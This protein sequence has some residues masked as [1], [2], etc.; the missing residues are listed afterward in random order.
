MDTSKRRRFVVVG[1]SVL[2][3]VFAVGIVILM[4]MSNHYFASAALTS[5]QATATAQQTAMTSSPPGANQT[6]PNWLTRPSFAGKVLHWTQIVYSYTAGGPDPANGQPLTGDIWVQVDTAGVPTTIHA[7]YTFTNGTFYQ[8]F[9]QTRTTATSIL[10]KSYFTNAGC[11]VVQKVFS[12]NDLLS[13]LP[14]FA[15]VVALPSSGYSIKGTRVPLPIPTTK[16]LAGVSPLTTYV[17]STT[18]QLWGLNR[19]LGNGMH[20]TQTMEVGLDSRVLATD[21]KLLDGKG[22][23]IQENWQTYGQLE[24]YDT[25]TVPNTVFSLSQHLGGGCHA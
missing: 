12:N 8:E 10:G 18:T 19:S 14:L 6:P 4:Q 2:L 3:C 15:N 9:V 16:P 21:T 7:R 24:V 20:D 23:M 5:Q 22:Q 1:V 17:Q 25:K 13:A 11:Q